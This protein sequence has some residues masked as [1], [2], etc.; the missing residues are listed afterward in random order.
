MI[1]R[2]SIRIYLLFA[3][4]LL[5]IFQ[6]VPGIHAKAGY[7]GELVQKSAAPLLTNILVRN[8]VIFSTE[9]QIN[10]FHFILE[11]S[12][13]YLSEQMNMSN[14]ADNNSLFQQ[15]FSSRRG[16]VKQASL[17]YFHGSKYK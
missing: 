13:N 10:T 15:N 6:S 7:D 8:P 9:I 4:I 14:T 2:Q 17:H 1:L 3:I 12:Y 11:K 16:S 5:I